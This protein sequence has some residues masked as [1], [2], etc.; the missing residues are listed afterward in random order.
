MRFSD[1]MSLP[2][3]E[4]SGD[5]DVKA[6]Q[7]CLPE[8]PLSVA[9]QVYS[10]HGR[11]PA[12]Q[13]QYGS[14][15]ISKINWQLLKVP[16]SELVAASSQFEGHVQN[17]ST[18]AVSIGTSGWNCLDPRPDVVAHWREHRTWLVPPI[19]TNPSLLIG[20]GALWLM[21]GH[22]RIGTLKGLL[23]EGYVSPDSL[24]QAWI[25]S[26]LKG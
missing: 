7:S 20:H 25:G 18:R 1:L 10:E 13:T 8:V 22:T 23:N 12:F 16:A 6:I 24:H 19:L 21:E 14:L 26:A 3:D 15:T 5:I 4:R 11:K 2:F 9:V 17:V